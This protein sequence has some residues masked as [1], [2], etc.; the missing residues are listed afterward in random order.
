MKVEFTMMEDALMLQ[1]GVG[2]QHMEDEIWERFLEVIVNS[3]RSKPK[4]VLERMANA[5][6]T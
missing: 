6:K 5:N 3:L 4:E 1:C 2:D